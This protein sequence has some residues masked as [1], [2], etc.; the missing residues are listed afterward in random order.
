MLRHP[1]CRIVG[2]TLLLFVAACS[3]PSSEGPG[4]NPEPDFSANWTPDPALKQQLEVAVPVG[5][6]T[7]QL[8]KGFTQD[9][10][11]P[12]ITPGQAYLQWTGPKGTNGRS[13]V[14]SVVVGNPPAYTKG[15]ALDQL[16]ERVLSTDR[17]VY[18]DWQQSPTEYGKIHGVKVAKVRWSGKTK[19]TGLKLNGLVAV[20]LDEGPS[21]VEITAVDDGSNDER[22]L[23]TIDAG[24][25]TLQRPPTKV[26]ANPNK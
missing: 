14:L 24:M 16:L 12:G 19:D 10:V 2:A 20:A 22:I 11:M 18:D 4:Q 23:K 3:R 21:Y 7:M 17:K 26:Y 1:I 6:Y 13:P 8:P 5:G 9:D 15:F 25:R